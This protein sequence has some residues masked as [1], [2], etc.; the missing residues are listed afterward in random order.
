MKYLL[1]AS[2]VLG[3]RISAENKEQNQTF[4]SLQSLKSNFEIDITQNSRHKYK[5]TTLIRIG[6]GCYV[7]L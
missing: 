1:S 4:L 5:M 2:W 6:T 7:N 3:T